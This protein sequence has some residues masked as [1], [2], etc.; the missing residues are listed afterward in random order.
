MSVSDLSGLEREPK[1]LFNLHNYSEKIMFSFILSTANSR[2]MKNLK[3]VS[4]VR[5]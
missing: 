4:N 1:R 2:V 3:S 5:Y